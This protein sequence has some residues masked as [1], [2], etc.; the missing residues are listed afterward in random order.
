MAG[1]ETPNDTP[2]V[3]IDAAEFEA[4][5]R[6]PRVA[7][8]L[9]EAVAYGEQVRAE[10]RDMTGTADITVIDYDEWVA[11]SKDPAWQRALRVAEAHVEDLRRKGRSE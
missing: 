2:N 7:A 8:F 5:Q 9:G 10:G 1:A 11:D 6:D 3:V 4:A